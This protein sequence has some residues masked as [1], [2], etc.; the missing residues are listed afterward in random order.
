VIRDSAPLHRKLWGEL[1]NHAQIMTQDLAEDF[2]ELPNVALAAY[3]VSKFALDHREGG[4]DVGPL[5]IVSEKLGSVRG[6]YGNEH[7]DGVPSLFLCMRPNRERA[8]MELDCDQYEAF[9]G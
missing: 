3:R 7:P 8:L 1:L 2:I 4:L 5:M 6:N 9:N